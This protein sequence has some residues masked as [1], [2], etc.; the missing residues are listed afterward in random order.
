[1]AHW[2]PVLATVW[3]SL[4]PFA[5]PFSFEAMQQLSF[6]RYAS[7]PWPLL[8]SGVR[9]TLVLIALAPLLALV[10]S[11]VISWIVVRSRF[12]WKYLLDIGAFLPLAIPGI[13]F[14]L[15][16]LLVSLFM[17]RTFM[18]LYGTV[19]AILVIYVLQHVSFGT[20]NING[21]LIGIHR[22]LEETAQVHGVSLVRRL[23]KVVV[24]LLT[25]TLLSTWLWLALLTYRELTVATFL[26]STNSITLPVV[27]WSAW[28]SGIGQSAAEAIL[29]FLVM[30]PLVALYWFLTRRFLVSQIGASNERY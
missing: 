10:F 29:A 24:P 23:A 30:A 8:L 13:V 21:A 16:M 3:I 20:R 26:S 12:R 19:A 9:N 6:G 28:Q 27:I 4:L 11:F 18:P 2:L 1:M 25:P 7:I 22:E 17:L 5:Q 15:S 14:A